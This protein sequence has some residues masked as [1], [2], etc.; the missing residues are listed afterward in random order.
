MVADTDIRARIDRATKTEAT[1]IL[2][3]MGLTTSETIRLLMKKI[4]AEK[5]FP[6]NPLIPND[7][8]IRAIKEAREG[9]AVSVGSVDALFEELNT[10]D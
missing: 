3:A 6:F 7:E 1:A 9:K 5:A 4:V 2:A 10:D 8:T